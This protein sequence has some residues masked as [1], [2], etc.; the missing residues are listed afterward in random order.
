MKID[1]TITVQGATPEQVMFLLGAV[2]TKGSPK[3]PR[4][5]TETMNGERPPAEVS[6]DG[7]KP[8]M[9]VIANMSSKPTK[10]VTLAD[11]VQGTESDEVETPDGEIGVIS[12][13]YRGKAAVEFEDG[14]GEIYTGSDLRMR[15][16]P[17]DAPAEPD[18]AP[19]EKAAEDPL[20]D[21][22]PQEEITRAQLLDTAR[23][24]VDVIGSEGVYKKLI[25]IT[26]FGKI[27]DIPPDQYRAAYAAL[28]QAAAAAD[29]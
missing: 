5:S 20:E 29:A 1:V 25:D 17:D 15:A 10:T 2:D 19:A 13:C 24:A 12:A 8:I 18:D 27:K 7:R 23:Q 16:E 4:R 11:G 14:T 22:E 3:E 9:D 6:T 26:G 21:D 28:K